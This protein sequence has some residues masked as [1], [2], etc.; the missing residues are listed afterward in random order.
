MSGPVAG[1]GILHVIIEE[2]GHNKAAFNEISQ[3]SESGRPT[4]HL[5]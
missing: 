4:M 3:S 5:G 1:L 2:L